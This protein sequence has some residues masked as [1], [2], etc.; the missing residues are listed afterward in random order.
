MSTTIVAD[1][2]RKS[3]PFMT[4]VCKEEKNP[5]FLAVTH[6]DVLFDKEVYKGGKKSPSAFTIVEILSQGWSK[7]PQMQKSK[8][9]Q[10]PPSKRLTEVVTLEDGAKAMKMWT[11]EKAAM[12]MERGERVDDCSWFVHNGDTFLMWLDENRIRD[13]ATKVCF[14]SFVF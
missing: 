4:A 13:M 10:S 7:V 14:S 9:K 3:R 5:R 12:N 2:R 11:F 1:F 8:Q 6:S